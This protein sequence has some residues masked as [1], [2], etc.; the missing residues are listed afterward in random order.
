[1]GRRKKKS[2]KGQRAPAI[3]TATFL[4]LG[5][6]LLFVG[7]ALQ[8]GGLDRGPVGNFFRMAAYGLSVIFNT[9]Y[10]I[11]VRAERRKK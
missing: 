6:G 11:K 9:Y 5:M 2:K 8:L 10:M 1:M 3:N 4:K 7:L